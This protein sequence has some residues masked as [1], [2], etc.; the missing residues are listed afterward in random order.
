[1]AG[2]IN[3]TEVDFD[4]IKSNLIDYLKSTG[5]F[6]DYNFEG[7]NLQVILNL[8]SYQA[9]LNAYSTNMIANESFLATSTLRTNVVANAR[10]VG[11]TP[12]SATAARS[13]ITFRYDLDRADYPGGFPKVLELQPGMAFSAGG[14]NDNITFNA[15]DPISSAVTV[16]GICIFEDVPIYEGVYLESKFVRDY[17]KYNQK[18]IL[19]NVNIDSTTIRVEVQEDPNQQTNEEYTQA[20]NLVEIDQY[21]RIFWLEEVESGY[22]ELTFGDGFFGKKLADGAIIRVSYLVTNGAVANNVQGVSNYAFVG[23]V[24]N[25]GGGRITDRPSVLSASTS[26]GGSARED[27]PSI[28]FRAPR[29][30]A[31]QNRCVVAEDYETIVKR[32]YPSAEAIYVFGGETLE[33]PQYGRVFVVV[34]PYGTDGL[35]NIAKN[36]IKENLD[37][38]RV[39]SLDIVI[40]SAEILNIEAVSTVYY[41]PKR[42][43]KDGSAITGDVTDALVLYGSSGSVSKFGGAVRY[44]RV[45]ATIDKANDAITRNQTD[46]RMRRDIE[47]LLDTSASYTICFENAFEN[48]VGGEPSVWSSG[49]QIQD[50]AKTY[51]FE[52]D[53]KG[54]MILFYFRE[55]DNKKKIVD[56]QFG[57]VDYTT[58]TVK[59]GELSP[60]TVVNTNVGSDIIEV[61]ARPRSQD[62]IAKQTIYLN[63]DTS[64]SDIVSIID[65]EISGS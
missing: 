5:Q 48:N 38:Y 40:A 35:T 2:A 39:A 61:R 43:S 65:T 42:T 36:F 54:N 51:Y 21:S 55:K 37:N 4:Q 34:K 1:M 12:S 62:V 30:Y 44:S 32:I 13:T 56:K 19:E 27:V 10:Q 15:I 29:E 18:F 59:V 45:V 17:T 11:Y 31:A 25:A 53:T 33:I 50:D 3:L 60:I 16:E 46:L 41:D 7:S 52:D 20:S 23:R 9:Q 28:K 64:K 8:I 14:G 58:G 24:T 63:I 47:A 49:F 57:T 26:T 22:Y 6:T